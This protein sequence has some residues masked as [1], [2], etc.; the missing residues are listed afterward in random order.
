MNSIVGN[1]NTYDILYINPDWKTV[2]FYTQAHLNAGLYRGIV[3]KLDAVY[4]YQSCRNFDQTNQWISLVD[5]RTVCS[6]AQ[7]PL[8]TMTSE[9][10]DST[11]MISDYNDEVLDWA[12]V[13]ELD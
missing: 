7:T 1:E 5:R 3:E 8:S 13:A 4:K 11:D 6:S 12:L 9:T 10:M 2:L